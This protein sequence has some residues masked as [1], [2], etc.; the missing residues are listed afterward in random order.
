M[1]LVNVNDSLTVDIKTAAQLLGVG[2]STLRSRFLSTGELPSI[3]IGR[4]R[5]IRRSAIE[6]LLER[7]ESEQAP[8]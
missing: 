3:L 1:T 4:R 7:L 6:G 8:V 5:L 2:P